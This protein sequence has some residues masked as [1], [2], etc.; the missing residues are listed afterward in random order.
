MRIG[1]LGSGAWAFALANLLAANGHFVIMWSI[2]KDIIK[3][4]KEN[5]EHPKFPGI[6]V[7]DNLSFTTDLKDAVVGVDV[8]VESVTT[9]GLRPVLKEI[10]KIE[11]LTVPFVMTSKG[12]EQGTGLL[13]PE[14][15]LEI[16]GEGHKDLIG[17]M[18]GP[19]LANEVLHK[20]PTSVVA[21]AHSEQVRTLIS[22]IFSSDYF[23]V[24]PNS[25]MFGVAFGGAMKNIIA[26]ASG[27]CDGLGFG[28]NAKAA[29]ITRGL[30]EM[31]K[32]APFKQAQAETLNG[33]SG[34]GDLCVTSLSDKSRN[35]QFGNLLASGLDIEK[36]KAKIGMVVEGSYTVVSALELAK[37][38]NTPLPIAEAVYAI[39]YDGLDPRVAVKQLFGREI[40]D[41]NL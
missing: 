25:D 14:I 4:L 26:I 15:A 41:E 24:Y 7:E 12:I 31:R 6:H 39:V 21:G 19:S 23:R 37:K 30:H 28:Q 40:K 36:A 27:I 32:L 13:L 3:G 18:S 22:Q 34:L 10:L 20:A 29:M 38:H 1:Y 5:R 9:K 8:I 33:L 11:K 16:L 17:C 35:Y 2:E